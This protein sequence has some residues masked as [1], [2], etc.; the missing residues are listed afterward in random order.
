MSQSLPSLARAGRAV[1]F[2]SSLL[3]IAIPLGAQ[4]PDSLVPRIDSVP[5]RDSV[6]RTA[7]PST[8]RVCAGGDVTL[9]TN[10]DTTWA[11]RNSARGGPRIQPLPD[12]AVLLRPLR[13]LV[14]DADILLLNVEG[15]IGEGPFEP[16]CGPN[17]RNCYAFRQP[18]SAAAALRALGG[19]APVVGNIANNHAG[20]AG[21]SGRR[22]TIRHLQAAGVHVTGED[23][24]ATVVT[25]LTGDT[26]AFLGFSTSSGPD[27]RDLDAVR[28]HVRR[29]SESYPRLVVTMHMG[30]EGASAQRTP[31]STEIFLGTV[32]RGNSVAFA[33]AAVESGADFVAGH[34]PH[35]MRAM[36]WLD[37]ALIMYS[38]GNL[39]TYGPFSFSEPMNRGGIG[40][41]VLASDGRVESAVLRSTVQTPP[42]RVRSDPSARAAILV[43]SLSR[44]DAGPRAPTIRVEAAILRPDTTSAARAGSS[45]SRPR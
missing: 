5:Q 20:D 3:L 30:A 45:G 11:V 29:A 35:V 34:G 33:R 36:E 16:K 6:E 19:A 28:R 26:V 15:A 14:Q 40:C 42:G 39:V 24:L 9:G 7:R 21:Q 32:N 25:T 12:P 4:R 23:T 18:I 27:P 38:L 22:E 17:S 37:D 44:L 2:A 8:A 31:D 41:A 10:L 43:D 1:R 13:P